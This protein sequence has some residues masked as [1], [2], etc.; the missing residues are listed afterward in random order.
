MLPGNTEKI[1]DLAGQT[2]PPLHFARFARPPLASPRAGRC[3]PGAR[4]LKI[5]RVYTERQLSQ[6]LFDQ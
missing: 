2:P 5:F 6:R 1:I 4:R 3:G